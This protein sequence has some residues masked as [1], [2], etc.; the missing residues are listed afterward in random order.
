M[1][2][3]LGSSLVLVTFATVAQAQTTVCGT[4]SGTWSLAGSPYLV[5]CDIEVPSGSTLTI[6]PGVSVL[7]Y[8]ATSIN[9]EGRLIANGNQTSR[10]TFDEIVAGQPWNRIHVSANVQDPPV[11]E[12]RFCVF[13]NATTAIYAYC[14][15]QV[16]G[17]TTLHIEVSDCLFESSVT[18]IHGD[19]LGWNAYQ[20]FT[21]H[22]RSAR[23]DPVI[24]RCV[25][26]N[27][28]MAIN[29]DI[30]GSCS[31][32]C[33]GAASDPIVR[34]NYFEAV[35]TAFVVSGGG[36]SPYGSGFPSFTNN[37][38]LNST[39]GFLANGTG[40]FPASIAN[41][42]FSGLETAVSVTGTHDVEYN[43][44]FGN[45]TDCIGCPGSF[46]SLVWS[47]A[48][49]DPCD[50]F[51]NIFLDPQFASEGV[52]LTCESPCLEAG[53]NSIPE[54]GETDLGGNARVL[55]DYVDIGAKEFGA[56]DCDV[57]L[58]ACCVR[59]SCVGDMTEGD[60]VTS[61]GTY[62]GNGTACE[63][64]TDGD[65][66]SDACDNCVGVAN[67]AQGDC[68]DDGLGDACDPDIDN[69]GVL[70]DDDVCDFTPPSDNV[71]P[72]GSLLGDLD[73]D[74]DVDLG[75]VSLMQLQFTGPGCSPSR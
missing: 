12:F 57:D 33:G 66:V 42:I 50:L 29:L 39:D 3:R 5:A 20:P 40:A 68:D 71:E 11:S 48:N 32:W 25:F 13:R 41:N 65:D 72:D 14:K 35:G 54:L 36:T 18:G 17:L 24:E 67:P 4:Q 55:C 2:L 38:V 56:C 64:D 34:N 49:E 45:T 75:D 31:T 74:C 27:L 26:S 1:Y 47:N 58:G 21:P 7:F 61:D 28:D 19:A 10:I 52:H 44:F 70:N 51:Y 69:D 8:E 43:D 9:V 6:E 46:G 37:T 63:D 23:L 73:G 53:S 22:R 62:A 15:G 60:C 59:E 30:T 16:D